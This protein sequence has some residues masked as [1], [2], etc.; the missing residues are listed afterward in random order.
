M[1][2]VLGNDP[3]KVDLPDL[4]D[5]VY[6]KQ[7]KF[8]SDTQHANSRDLV[9]AINSGKLVVLQG[10][11][12]SISTVPVNLPVAVPKVDIKPD[13]RFDLLLDKLESLEKSVSEPRQ[14]AQTDSSVVEILL[15]RIAKLEER[16][17]ELSK[18]GGSDPVLVD[19]VRK[20]ADRVD[21]SS[22]DTAILDRLE[23]I[24][25]QSGG[26]GISKEPV[27]AYVSV[28]EVYVPTITVEDANSHI[29]LD[30]RAV[31]APSGD[32]DASLAALK[33]LKQSK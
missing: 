21:S 16:I 24:L 1:I 4:G 25:A 11:G 28:D 7:Q 31:G 32:L 27:D 26:A 30:V 10:G 23:S 6:F 13:S 20:L 3:H 9:R 33:R 14:S 18:Q 15:G 22:K 8:F 17:E 19:A 5:V 29:K 12:T 2:L